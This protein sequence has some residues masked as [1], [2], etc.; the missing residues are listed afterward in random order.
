MSNEVTST[1]TVSRDALYKVLCALTGPA[2]YIRELQVTRSL[3]ELGHPNPIDT[4]IEEYKAG[5]V[6]NEPAQAAVPSVIPLYDGAELRRETL[7]GI[8]P[9][10]GVWVLYRAGNYIRLLNEFERGFVDAAIDASRTQAK[11]S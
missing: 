11:G 10:M 7:T 3:H 9:D 2:Y 1:I 6:P 5:G 8:G 4:L